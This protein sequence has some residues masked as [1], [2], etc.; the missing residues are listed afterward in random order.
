[1]YLCNVFGVSLELFV[2]GL[3]CSWGGIEFILALL[4]VC[5]RRV[6]RMLCNY[7]L[8]LFEGPPY[9]V[10]KFLG[11]IHSC[12]SLCQ[13]SAPSDEESAVGPCQGWVSLGFSRVALFVS[14]FSQIWVPARSKAVGGTTDSLF[15]GELSTVTPP[16]QLTLNK[17]LCFQK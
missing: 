10:A 1:M 14:E 7:N 16:C 15:F 6:L 11:R 12:I 4:L 13:C 17:C 9:F 8:V 5:I 2:A 3:W